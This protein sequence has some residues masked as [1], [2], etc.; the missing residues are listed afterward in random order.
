MSSPQLAPEDADKFAAQFKP[1][2]EDEASAEKPAPLNPAVTLLSASHEAPPPS[3]GTNGAATAVA[4]QPATEPP[5]P[6]N[7]QIEQGPSVVV[8]E[9]APPPKPAPPKGQGMTMRMEPGMIPPPP[10]NVEAAPKLP[11]AP[12]KPV[13]YDDDFEPKKEKS[14]LPLVLGAAAALLV[15]GLGAV[16]AFSGGSKD[17]GSKDSAGDASKAEKP[18]AAPVRTD[19]PK[20][21]PPKDEPK[22][23][24]PKDEPKPKAPA[25]PEP[26][27]PPVAAAPPTPGPMPKATPKDPPAAAPAAPKKPGKPGG[28]V[29]DTPF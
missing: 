7:V 25:K 18:A 24:P 12:A 20:V 16:F 9:E 4:S 11:P 2:W 10:A 29:R 1:A 27:P 28:I 19:L 21:E 15:V 26:A 17:S 8:A 22:P 14:K 6:A 5:K 23:E 13:T 3:S